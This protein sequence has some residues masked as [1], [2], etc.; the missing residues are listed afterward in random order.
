MLSLAIFL[1]AFLL[2]SLS[3]C[4]VIFWFT[5]SH[6]PGGVQLFC[7]SLGALPVRSSGFVRGVGWSS[8]LSPLPAAWLWIVVFS[9]PCGLVGASATFPAALHPASLWPLG[10]ST[11]SSLG[12][13]SMCAFLDSR[14]L[15]SLASWLV[16]GSSLP[17]LV[18][19]SFL[20]SGVLALASGSCLCAPLVCILL[21]YSRLASGFCFLDVFPGPPYVPGFSLLF[22]LL[23]YQ[24]VSDLFRSGAVSGLL[25]LSAPGSL[26]PLR[27]FECDHVVCVPI[28]SKVSSELD[29][30]SSVLCGGVPPS[31]PVHRP[32]LGWP[33]RSISLLRLSLFGLFLGA[34]LSEFSSFS[35]L[36]TFT[37]TLSFCRRAPGLLFA[38]GGVFLPSLPS[39]SVGSPG[40]PRLGVPLCSGGTLPRVVLV[41]C[42]RLVGSAPFLP[43]SPVLS[44]RWAPPLR[45]YWLSHPTMVLC[46]FVIGCLSPI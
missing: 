44:P 23:S 24:S 40:S 39:W 30:S 16:L 42:L 5:L 14:L 10:C 1:V 9:V 35:P 32:S 18:I 34:L 8:W 29:G 12:V 21:L 28:C 22:F 46:G 43:S 6:L 45:V 4:E 2:V 33:T 27:C 25:V 20:L 11:I 31:P 37:L 3:S 38:S 17:V 13:S 7:F 26:L 41:L 19:C 36:V 15:C